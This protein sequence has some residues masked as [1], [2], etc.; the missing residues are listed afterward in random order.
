MK[1]IRENIQKYLIKII[2]KKIGDDDDPVDTDF[3]LE[4]NVTKNTEL[5][6][7]TLVER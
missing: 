3:D 6:T 7:Y 5:S 4:T 1:E 2:A